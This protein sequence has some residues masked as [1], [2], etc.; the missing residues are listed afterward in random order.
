MT[1]DNAKT[2]FHAL[3]MEGEVSTWRKKYDVGVGVQDTLFVLEFAI[4]MRDLTNQFAS[5]DQGKAAVALINKKRKRDKF[6]PPERTWKSFLLQSIEHIVREAT[7]ACLRANGAEV[8]SPEH[9][10]VR[11]KLPP[12][13]NEEAS[14]TALSDA[15]T[16]IPGAEY[17]IKIQAADVSFEPGPLEEEAQEAI[18]FINHEVVAQLFLASD[19]RHLFAYT[20]DGWRA[21]SRGVWHAHGASD[22]VQRALYQVVSNKLA[23]NAH[24]GKLGICHLSNLLLRCAKCTC[25]TQ[26]STRRPTPTRTPL[27][28]P[29]GGCLSKASAIARS[30]QTIE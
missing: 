10:E 8:Y 20:N 7:V 15:A 6:T 2:L 11:A 23:R 29:T 27:Q 5:T 14:E 28:F 18:A 17:P 24:L 19:E 26:A 30:T 16:S 3:C 12:G 13:A 1:R 25:S 21:F 9:D 22:L 4:A